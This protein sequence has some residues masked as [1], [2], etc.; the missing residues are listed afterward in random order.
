MEGQYDQQNPRP[1]AEKDSLIKNFQ[2][3]ARSCAFAIFLQF[4]VDFLNKD[5]NDTSLTNR[6]RPGLLCVYLANLGFFPTHLMAI[7][8]EN[9]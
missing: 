6:L 2:F 8:K 4:L 9:L 5:T 1:R 3:T 7:V